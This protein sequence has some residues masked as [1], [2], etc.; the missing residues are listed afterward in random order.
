[1]PNKP[2][3]R[4]DRPVP[5]QR[6]N[7]WSAY[8]VLMDSNTR[9]SETRQGVIQNLEEALKVGEVTEKDFYI[10]QALQLLALEENEEN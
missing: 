3:D 9:A 5:L 4:C 1:M 6:L 10:R 2:V 7:V 8:V